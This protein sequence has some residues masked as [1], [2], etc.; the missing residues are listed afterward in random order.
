MGKFKLKQIKA[1][2]L[3][4][5]LIL[6]SA[7]ILTGCSGSRT[8]ATEK[9]V[10]N[11]NYGKIIATGDETSGS[12]EI[13]YFYY[14]PVSGSIA[15]YISSK[16]CTYSVKGS[17]ITGTVKNVSNGD[18]KITGTVNRSFSVI[19]CYGKTYKS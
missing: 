2:C 18:A 7:T 13:E 3:S 15:G 11:K 16:Q 17:T 10:Y 8:F 9:A 14:K 12:A 6:T 19:T 4:V 1:F 5:C